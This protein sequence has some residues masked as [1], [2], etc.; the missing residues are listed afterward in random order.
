MCDGVSF[1]EI[2]HDE[3]AQLQALK[4][5]MDTEY[6]NCESFVNCFV[7]STMRERG[8]EG[9]KEGGRETDRHTYRQIDRETYRQTTDRHNF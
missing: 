5:A 6:V 9:E 3:A 7:S 1:L 8:R 2:S 4:H